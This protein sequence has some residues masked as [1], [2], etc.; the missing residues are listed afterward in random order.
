MVHITQSKKD[1]QKIEDRKEGKDGKETVKV[2]PD[3]SIPN[4]FAMMA[5]GAKK[6]RLLIEQSTPQ[7]DKPKE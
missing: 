1:R 2:V 4:V 5:E 3:K 7:E 6:K